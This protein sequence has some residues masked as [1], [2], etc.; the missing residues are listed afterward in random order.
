MNNINKKQNEETQL[1]FLFVQRSLY[2]ST[3]KLFGWRT[4]IAVCLAVGGP[5]L[6]SLDSQISAYVAIIAVVYLLLDNLVLQKVESSQKITAAKIQEL[7][8][9]NVLELSWNNIVTGKQPDKEII[10]SILSKN[11]DRNYTALQ[12]VDW[13]SSDVSKVDLDTG[14]FL[15]QRSNVW[16]DSSLRKKYLNFLYA[17]SA[18]VVLGLII[19]ATALNLTMGVFIIGVLL[20]VIPLIELLIKQINEH[21][22][23]DCCSTDLKDN[24]NDTLSR[25][26][27]GEVI[28][29]PE[30][31]ARTYQDEIYRHRVNVLWCLIGCTGY[32][33]I[34]KKS[35]CNLAFQ[36]P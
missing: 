9:T 16:W 12:L 24:I 31:L 1:E 20:P 35:K 6:T 29:N 7:F 23:S 8:D 22:G 21:H 17:F 11:S 34:S 15:C 18:L 30:S 13:Y 10:A 4:V 32:L 27:N 19:T 14:R 36:R 26:I 25:I 5:F 28:N 3:K 2:S 33:R